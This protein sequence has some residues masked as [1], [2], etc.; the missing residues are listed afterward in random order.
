ML[1]CIHLIICCKIKTYNYIKQKTSLNDCKVF[2]TRNFISKYDKF[3]DL[4][5]SAYKI[6]HFCVGSTNQSFANSEKMNIYL[7]NRYKENLSKNMTME[8][9]EPTL[10]L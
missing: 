6:T 5:L 8:N 4:I 7:K 1:N 10:E 3:Y 2:R 9:Q